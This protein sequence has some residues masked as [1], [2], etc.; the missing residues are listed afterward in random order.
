MQSAAARYTSHP[1]VVGMELDDQA[2]KLA[3]LAEASG[4]ASWDEVTVTMTAANPHIEKASASPSWRT[5][6]RLSL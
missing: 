4:P 6:R 2:L 5:I 1:D 3:D